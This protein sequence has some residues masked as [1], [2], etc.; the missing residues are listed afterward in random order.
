MR[1][2]RLGA[3]AA[4]LVYRPWQRSTVEAFEK[5]SAGDAKPSGPAAEDAPAVVVLSPEKVEAARTEV[6]PVA[7]RSL[8]RSIT[9][10]G[11]L[12][13]DDTRHISVRAATAG[14]LADVLVKPG[15]A[16]IVGQVLAILSSPE[17]GTARA[18]VLQREGELRVLE[19]EL[20]WRGKRMRESTV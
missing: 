13:Y 11:R 17:V 20:S 12:Q 6:E 4:A 2:L 7:A 5:P 15:D 18:D 9:V 16:V 14:V 8:G 10:P 1:S 3:G 19:E